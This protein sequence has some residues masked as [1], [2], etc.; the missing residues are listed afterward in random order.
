MSLDA[1]NRTDRRTR[2]LVAKLGLDGHDRG[3]KVVAHTLRDAGM[4]VIYTGLRR[5]ARDVVAM[6]VDEDVDVIGL[7]ILSGAHLALAQQVL[8][9]LAVRGA[10]DEIAVVVG[11]TISATD[12]AV[13]R[14]MGV[15]E[16]FGVRSPLAEL[17]PRVQALVSADR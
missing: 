14:Q 5:T 13:L 9:E 16:V 15:A 11:G 12:D 10:R 8:D 4:E 6:A 7:S 2:V 17:A 3:A 1:T